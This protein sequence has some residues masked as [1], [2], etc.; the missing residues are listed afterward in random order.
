MTVL[1][2]YV[3]TPSG[4]A[5]VEAGIAEAAAH[6]DDVVILNSPRRGSTVDANLVGEDVGSRLVA[7]A[8]AHGVAAQIDHTDHGADVVDAFMSALER[9]SARLVVVGLR[10]RSPVGK[11]MMGSAAQRLLL[12]L[13][14]PVL[15]VK[16]AR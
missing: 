9:T 7:A 14:A 11:F 15:A 2:G 5:A 4:E 1:I 16:P 10:P 8:A 12:E 6:S 13:D 3:P